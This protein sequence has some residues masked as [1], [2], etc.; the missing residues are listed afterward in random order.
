MFNAC[1]TAPNDNS[2]F[3]FQCW[4]FIF[5]TMITCGVKIRRKVSEHRYDIGVKSQGHLYFKPVYGLQNLAFFIN[6]AQFGT[7]IAYGV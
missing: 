4:V 1:L 2:S 7:L 5:I 3:I 6:G